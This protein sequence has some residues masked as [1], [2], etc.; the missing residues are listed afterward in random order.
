MIITLTDTEKD[1]VGMPCPY[2]PQQFELGDEIHADDHH[3]R[4]VGC[5][6]RTDDR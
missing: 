1:I 2:C 6:P 4:H 5:G 3:L